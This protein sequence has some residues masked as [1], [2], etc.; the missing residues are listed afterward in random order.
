M[1]D[2][3]EF[4]PDAPHRV[5]PQ[6]DH[7]ELEGAEATR[8]E[9]A[10]QPK[11]DNRPTV[12]IN[13][14]RPTIELHMVGRPATKPRRPLGRTMAAV[15]AGL[16]AAGT[17]AWLAKGSAPEVPSV[18]ANPSAP[19]LVEP[20]N[21]PVSIETTPPAPEAPAA[22][23]FELADGV[24]DLNV[25]IT[26]TGSGSWFT[27]TSPDG[28]AIRPRVEFGDGIVRVFADKISEEG[29]SR[30]DV[31]LSPEVAWSVRMRGGV[32]TG[33]FDLTGGRVDRID[34]LGGA[35][36][37][38]IALPEQDAVVPVQMSGGV[39]DW[40]IRTADQIPVR[41]TLRN[42]AGTVVLYGDRTQGVDRGRVLTATDG[43]GGLDVIADEGV[44][45]LTV[46]A[47]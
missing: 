35:A 9:P 19:V 18:V 3:S 46:S 31:L 14:G 4:W 47:A 16:L 37:I 5:G 6:P 22:A 30:V 38:D 13:T 28:S 12:Q 25:L 17:A 2:I 20:E 1:P 27:A 15:L 29:S 36:A 44:G 24:T 33:T 42:G 45:T 23:T 10:W 11:V 40:R 41:A 8:T 32:R 43:S 26:G 21:P 34:L 39:N 7:Y